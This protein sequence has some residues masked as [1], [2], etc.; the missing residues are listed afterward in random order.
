VVVMTAKM[1][2]SQYD[3]QPAGFRPL[4]PRI[5]EAVVNR[6]ETMARAVH[7]YL[8]TNNPLFAVVNTAKS[9]GTGADHRGLEQDTADEQF[10]QMFYWMN[11]GESGWNR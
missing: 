8:A 9:F 11:L 2:R 3:D 7:P 6:A 1:S 10:E 4:R 5:D